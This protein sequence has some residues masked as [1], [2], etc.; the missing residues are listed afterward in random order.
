M[1]AAVYYQ[2]GGPEVFKYEEVPD[3]R[4]GPAASS[5]R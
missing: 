3:P 5:S 2:T 1:K 4:H